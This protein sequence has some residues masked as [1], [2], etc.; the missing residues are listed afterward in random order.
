MLQLRTAGYKALDNLRSRGEFPP[1]WNSPDEL[2]M[3]TDQF[4]TK[5]LAERFDVSS[6]LGP[7]FLIPE[8]IDR[9]VRTRETENM[10]DSSATGSEKLGWIRALDRMNQMTQ[11]YT[12]QTSLLLPIISDISRRNGPARILELASGSGG[13][14]F[15]LAEQA[16]KYGL[17]I[18]VTATDIV[19][20]TISEGNRLAAAR[21]LPVT[22]R[23]MNAFDFEGLEKGSIDVVVISQS[24]HHF[25]PGQ[26]ALMIAQAESHGASAFVGI[27]GHRS[28]LLLGGVPLV[29][30]LQGIA[31]F[32]SDGLTSARKFYSELELEIIAQIATGRTGHRV[33]SSWPLSMLH[34]KLNEKAS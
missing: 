6:E 5:F 32:T 34:A 14:A 19:P 1:G 33:V 18:T 10:D 15:A 12:H 17:D 7:G 30:S 27:D 8:M 24:M 31:A 25:C 16:G 11:S 29:A 22:F 13:L 9:A 3:V 4:M 2:E 21:D 28:L 23:S 20:E 26:L